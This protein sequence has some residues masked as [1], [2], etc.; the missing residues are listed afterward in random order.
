MIDLIFIVLLHHW[1]TNNTN[2]AQL[3]RARRIEEARAIEQ[4]PQLH[5]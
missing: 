5:E 3:S 4:S 1:M 2:T